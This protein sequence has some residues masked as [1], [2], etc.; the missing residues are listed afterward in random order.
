MGESITDRPKILYYGN[1]AENLIVPEVSHGSE[2]IYLNNDLLL[3]TEQLPFKS[4]HFIQN[5]MAAIGACLA[6]NIDH[7]AIKT[8]ISSYKPLERRFSVLSND[9]LIIDD[10]A[11]NP[12]GIIATIKSASKMS[13]GTLHIVFAIRGSRGEIINRLNAEA[14]VEGIDGR[15]IVLV[16][17][18]STEVVDNLNTVNSSEK[19]VVLELFEK[20]TGNM[21]L[22]K[23]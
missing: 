13:K 15:D 9:P 23:I 12:D 1:D 10:F 5:T 14:L 21:F 3:E 17:T 20:I 4:K 22:K 7:N 16:V 2:G 8:G 11:H 19:D 6:L 18:S